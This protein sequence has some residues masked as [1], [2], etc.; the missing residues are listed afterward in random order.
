MGSAERREREKE[1][2]Q[3]RIVEAARD[4]VAERGLDGLSMRAIAERIEYSP[5]TIYLYFQDKEALLR[6]LMEEAF[7]LLGEYMR[8]EVANAGE[9]ASAAQMHKCTGRAYVS[10]ALENTAYFRIMFELPGVPQIECPP[11]VEGD[12]MLTDDTS[13]GFASMLLEHAVEAGELTMPDPVEGALIGWALVHG[14]TSLFLSGRLGAM[15]QSREDFLALVESSMDAI[16]AGW[17]PRPAGTPGSEPRQAARL[18]VPTPCHPGDPKG[19]VAKQSA[20]DVETA[21]SASS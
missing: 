16:W 10:F 20:Q 6:A 2:L 5:A 17:L 12:L 1:N 14:L 19:A 8:R 18:A 9:G 7:T 21:A 13:F 11:V 15:V 4:L 3:M